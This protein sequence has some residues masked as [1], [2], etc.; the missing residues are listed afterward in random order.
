MGVRIAVGVPIA[1]GVLIGL[2]VDV[3]I[4]AGVLIGLA[5]GALKGAF[6]PYTG[7]RWASE[8]RVKTP[9]IL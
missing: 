1:V 4:A 9:R 7:R 2:A 3:L 8:Y 5:E 6:R